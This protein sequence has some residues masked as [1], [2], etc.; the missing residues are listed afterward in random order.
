VSGA[1][2][3]P[4]LT[5]GKSVVTASLLQQVLAF[6][7][8]QALI[9]PHDRIL[10][11]VSGGPDST[12]LLHL[13][14][15]SANL[16]PIS[17]GVAHFDHTLR[18][19]ASRAD[20]LWV[21]DL[22]DSLSLPCYLG[23]GAVLRHQQEKKISLQTA[24]RELR[25]H[26][27]DEIK[28]QHHYHTVALGHTAD[29]QVELFF[30]RL[31]RG[32]GPEGMKGMWPFSPTG[33]I[34]PLLGT[35][36]A[37]IVGWLESE[38][39]SYRLDT[40]N[41]SRCYRRNQ[42]R[43]DLLP[44]LMAYNPRLGDAVVRFQT[45]L[46]EQEDYLQQETS[47]ALSGL[48]MNTNQ[49]RLYLSVTRLLAM[50]PAL[51]KRVMRLACAQAGVPLDRL[52]FRHM[53][54]ALHLCRQP[55]P[56]GEISLPGHWRLVREGNQVVWQIEPPP[57][58]PKS[59][60]VLPD[61]EAG[62]Y[63]LLGWTFTWTTCPA[64]GEENVTPANPGTALMDYQR[65]QFPLRLRT[66]QAGDRFQPIGMTGTKKLQDFFVDV[67][68]PRSQRPFIPLL[69]SRDQI[70]WVVGHRLAESVKVSPQTR[71]LLRIE[72]LPPVIGPGSAPSP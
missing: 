48:R 2:P 15:R 38:G 1:E 25:W 20:A 21:A 18:G 6:I 50:H 8:S 61:Q 3:Y 10:V 56:A 55:Q 41:L 7:R 59:E 71:I 40:S 62:A 29:D 11:G 67:K 5:Y 39:L 52:T 44:Q 19:V 36:K 13:L 72:A 16:W 68:I 58:P 31:L 9:K 45:L 33:I 69:L 14:H 57:L 70:V 22:A 23:T 53:T 60:Y 24:A 28:Q 46:Q 64:T 27:F 35:S 65:L 30:L 37:Q 4:W 47:H 43:L 42:L 32:A 63:T 66:F 54:A 17:L 51:Q 26:F 49:S 12:A 34:R